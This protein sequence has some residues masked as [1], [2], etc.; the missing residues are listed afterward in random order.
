[1]TDDGNLFQ[2]LMARRVPQITGL[3]IAASWLTVEMGQWIVGL[4]NW[5]EQLVV[6]AFV[7]LAA[8]LPSAIMLAWNHGAPGRDRWPRGEKI[9]V[10][11]NA[12]LAIG[13]VAVVVVSVPPADSGETTGYAGSAVAERTLVD[14]TGNERVFKVAREGFHRRVAAFFWTPTESAGFEEDH[15]YGYAIAWLLSVDLGRDPLLTSLHP[16]VAT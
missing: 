7:L 8:M 14:E 12:L 6:Y 16:T 10:P 5:P 1:M 4:L 3:Y 13:A 15:W 11:L 9:A 2:K